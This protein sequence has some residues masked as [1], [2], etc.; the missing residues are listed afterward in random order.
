MI[1]A[2]DETPLVLQGPKPEIPPGFWE[3][4]WPAALA[5]LAVAA[6]ACCVLETP[7]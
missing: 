1:A 7:A 2:L 4:H 6:T 3:A 5:V